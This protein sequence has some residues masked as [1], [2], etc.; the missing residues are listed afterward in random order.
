[1]TKTCLAVRH[2]AFEDMGAFADPVVAAGYDLRLLDAPVA[3]LSAVDPLEPDLLVLLGGPVGVYETDA[4]TF[5]SV[6]IKWAKMR[7]AHKRPILGLC[8]GAQVMTVALGAAVRPGA[9]EIGI[10]SIEL[11]HDGQ[12][13]PLRYLADIPVLH[14]HGDAMELPDAADHLARTDACEVQA[15][16]VGAHALALQF[17][18]EADPDAIEHWLVGHAHEIGANGLDPRVIRADMA[19]DGQ[20][21]AAAGRKMLVEWLEG[22]TR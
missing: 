11:T 17:H 2:V 21:I 5:L 14:W 4:Y 13:G 12:N 10:A 3:D 1:M 9:K 16:S 7:L 20:R 8:L 19:R 15:W 22:L 18:A 6:E